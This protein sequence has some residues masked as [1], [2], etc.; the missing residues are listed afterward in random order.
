[1]ETLNEFLDGALCMASAVAGLVFLRYWRLS[2]ER[3]FVYFCAAFWM[4]AVQWALLAGFQ[5]H[6]E[7]RPYVYG[8]RLAAFLLIL[9]GIVDKNLRA[10]RR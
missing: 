4:L 5:P 8:I 7:Y 2:S 10:K 9:A 6:D 3:L 1:M